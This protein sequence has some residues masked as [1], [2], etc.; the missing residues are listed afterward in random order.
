MDEWKDEVCLHQI[1]SLSIWPQLNPLSTLST[2]A[3]V[4]TVYD[5]LRILEVQEITITRLTDP[6]PTYDI[7]DLLTV[8]SPEEILDRYPVDPFINAIAVAAGL[9][10]IKMATFEPHRFVEDPTLSGI[11]LTP[12]VG[13]RYEL[14]HGVFLDCVQSDADTVRYMAVEFTKLTNEEKN[15][16]QSAAVYSLA[17]ATSEQNRDISELNIAFQALANKRA[18]AHREVLTSGE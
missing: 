6:A 15:R 2:M 12:T 3:R 10:P 1:E 16:K 17:V 13:Q 5:A 11:P 8:L 9:D 4:S 14:A 18:E 7:T